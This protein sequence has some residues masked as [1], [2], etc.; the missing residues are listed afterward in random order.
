MRYALTATQMRTAEATAVTRGSVTIGELMDR[1]GHALAAEVS[2]RV[3]AGDVVVL[4]GPGNNGGDGWVAARVLAGS[5][6]AARVLTVRALDDL[7]ADARAAAADAIAS[8]VPWRL[9]ADLDAAEYLATAAVIIDA[10]FGFGLRGPV[11]EPY[12]TLV[13]Q[14]NG[15]DGFVVS[16][17]VPSGVD[18]D[19]GGVGGVAIAA[20]VTVTF[21]ALK[22]GLLL[23]DGAACAGDVVVADLGIDPALLRGEGALEL[24]G[25]ADIRR[26]IPL[27]Q[28]ADH[29]GS[30]GRV[31]VVAGSARYAGAAV[32]VTGGAMRMGAGY[33]YAVTSGEVA[34]LVLSAWPSALV[35][36]VAA[37]PDGSPGDAAA[38]ITA[39]EDADAVVVGPGLGTGDAVPATVRA[40]LGAFAGPLLLDAD[41]L[42]VLAGDTGP[43]RSRAR[44]IVITPHAG[45]AA[46]LLGMSVAEVLRAPLRAAERLSG[47]DLVCLLKGPVTIVAGDGRA[48]L[49]SSGGPELARAGTG[50]VLSGMIGTLLA[51]G[52]RPFDA[53]VAGAY[54]HGRAGAHGAA[55]LTATSVVGS[56]LP[57]FILDAVREVAG[58]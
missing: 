30:R 3:P 33:V 12:A 5:G 25:I 31:A 21:S 44:P 49:V 55:R 32:L 58:G 14:V 36:R 52:V 50:D 29:K 4:C 47:P 20:D 27:P 48:A 10:L 2:R 37:G 13:S 42:N 18:S 8:G 17:D 46:R 16:A 15:S 41:A 22:P 35:R 57:R 1:A 11:R 38:V 45:E 9:A 43:L 6:R 54:L 26:V 7:G 56:D 28:R 51:Q 39:V 19:S 53:A 24:P 40:L 34:D 23:G